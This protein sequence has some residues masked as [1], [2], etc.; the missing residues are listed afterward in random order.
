[1]GHGIPAIV[2]ALLVSPL[3]MLLLHLV[4]HRVRR[5]IGRPL[6]AHASAVL[7]I[8][9]GQ[10]PLAVLVWRIGAVPSG[11][12][13]GSWP[14]VAYELVVY[15]ALA[16]LYLDVVNIAETSLHVHIVLEVAWA[17][18]LPVEALTA[19]YSGGH[20]VDARLARLAGLGQIRLVGDRYRLTDRKMLVVAR[21]LDV[22]RA[23]LGFSM[24]ADAGANRG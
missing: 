7:A 20:M 11:N 14:A 5:A 4:I 9:I 6:T 2:L 16:I 15:G 21:A 18:H 12:P 8:V 19:R 10:L 24:D 1:M 3:V 22:W 13:L 17:G 23:L